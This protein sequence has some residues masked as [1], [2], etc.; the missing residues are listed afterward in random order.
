MSPW[1]VPL[2]GH[3][4]KLDPNNYESSAIKLRQL[5]IENRCSIIALGNGSGCRRFEDMLQQKIKSGFFGPINVKYKII[6]E[7]GVSYYSVTDEAKKDLPSFAPHMIGA[8]SIARKL[9]DPLSELVKVDPK[10]LQVGMYMVC[11]LHFTQSLN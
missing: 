5:M 1:L 2:D 10:R 3:I 7:S 6:N 4:L 9:I 11:A 8:I